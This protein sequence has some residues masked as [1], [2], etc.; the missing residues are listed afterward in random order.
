LPGFVRRHFPGVMITALVT[1]VVWS[2]QG[3]LPR[4]FALVWRL[5]LPAWPSVPG[6]ASRRP[7]GRA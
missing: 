2:I 1:T 4:V 6:W 5:S 3:L 7:G